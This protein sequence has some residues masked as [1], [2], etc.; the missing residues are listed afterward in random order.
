MIRIHK[1][2]LFAAL[3]G[4]ASCMEDK[5]TSPELGD[6]AATIGTIS[7]Y[8][9]NAI[10]AVGQTLQLTITGKTLT[11]EPITQF[12]SIVY[13]YTSN[14]ADTVKIKAN[15]DGTIEALTVTQ[16]YSPVI[17]SIVPFKNGVGKS[18]DIIIQVTQNALSGL[19]MSIQP[20]P[21]D[22]AK[23]ALG[24]YKYIEP[25][26]SNSSG[27]SVIAPQLRMDVTREGA[28]KI[29]GYGPTCP[30][31]LTT[32][33]YGAVCQR[34]SGVDWA[35]DIIGA[36][37]YEGSAWVYATVN[38]YGT[39]L[40]DSVEYTVSPP[41]RQ[42]T[43][44]SAYQSVTLRNDSEGIIYLSPGGTWSFTNGLSATLGDVPISVTFN[45]PSAASA[46]TIGGASG[47]IIDLRPGQGT[48]RRFMTAGTYTWTAIA[49]GTVKPFAGQTTGGTIIVKP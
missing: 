41:Y 47:N 14:R 7:V 31:Q 11:G 21:P 25:V 36:Q 10:M 9:P 43:Y 26:I 12:D 18:D 19:S 13:V 16:D 45:D 30:S 24:E 15:Q 35:I 4:S 23:L 40:K 22:S 8:P 33:E 6:P 28:Q 49:G 29:I 44:I 34:V 39:V 48:Q 32:V 17:L 20:I 2:V 38:A 3:V 42:Q 1:L 27:E 46:T 37:G 5:G